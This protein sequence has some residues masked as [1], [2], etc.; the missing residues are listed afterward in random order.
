MLSRITIEVDF[1]KNNLPIIQILQSSS[2]DVRDKLVAAFCQSL[3]HTSTWCKIQFTGGTDI[4]NRWQITPITPQELPE[5]IKL[6][7]AVLSHRQ[8]KGQDVA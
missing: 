4:V 8:I 1:D 3:Q 2:D 5:E 6:M 7:E